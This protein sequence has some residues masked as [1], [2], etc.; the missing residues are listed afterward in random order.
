MKE[1]YYWII[2]AVVI[3]AGALLIRSYYKAQMNVSISFS[4]E[5]PS[6]AYVYQKVSLPLVVV[7]NGTAVKDFEIGILL[8]GNLTGVYNVTLAGGK[9]TQI[10][11][12][13]T[14]TAPGE[15]NLTAVG[16]PAKLYNLADRS[17]AT[18]SFVVDVL[19]ASKADPA[20][21]LPKNATYLYSANLDPLGYVVTSYLYQNYS[22]VQFAL[23]DIPSV[24]SFL[25]PLLHLTSGYTENFS[26]AGA[27]YK[28]GKAYS[29]WFS[30]YVSP[31][32][33]A[34][35]AQTVNLTTTNELLGS[36]NITIVSLTG[37]TTLCGWYE[38]GWVKTFSFEGN[39]TCLAVLQKGGTGVLLNTSLRNNFPV[40]SNTIELGNLSYS[41]PQWQKVGKMVVGEGQSIL[42]SVLWKNFTQNLICKGI[43]D[44]VNGTSYCSTYFLPTS[45]TLGNTSLIRTTAYLGEYNASVFSLVNSSMI[46]DQLDQNIEVIRMF[47]LTGTSLNFT[48]GI[49][50]SCSFPSVFSCSNATYGSSQLSLRLT[51]TENYSTRL[52][53]I[54]CFWNGI[55]PGTVLNETLLPG[56]SLNITTKCYNNSVTISGVPLNLNLHLLLNYSGEFVKNE[57]V[58]HTLSKTIEGSAFII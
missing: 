39:S 26:Y 11:L 18:G 46:F 50:N 3:V 23:S 44:Q 51:N 34:V 57:T 6:T 12:T 25:S 41:S 53:A 48:S 14:F 15:Y 38:D 56:A 19:G 22:L 49:K 35:G 52:N 10:D 55:G 7:N 27:D 37:N 28:K 33:I 42:Y 29:L 1:I 31:A 36:K 9:E 47:N 21:L 16:D 2:F 43:V 58:E 8:D 13:H 45:G 4:P 30:G 20:S 54:G 40:I 32:I 24:N 5:T 17:K